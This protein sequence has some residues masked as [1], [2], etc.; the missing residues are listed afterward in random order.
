MAFPEKQEDV[1]GGWWWQRIESVESA[2]SDSE[3]ASLPYYQ[4]TLS[5]TMDV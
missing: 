1:T 5:C 2:T 4:T 3:E